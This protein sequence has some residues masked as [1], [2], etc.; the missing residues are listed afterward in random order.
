MR[1]VLGGCWATA[2]IVSL[3]CGAA[4][5]A[6]GDA[7]QPRRGG[8]AEAPVAAPVVESPPQLRPGEIVIKPTGKKRL[9]RAGQR[10]A[11]KVEA[12]LDTREDEN[13]PPPRVVSIGS[14]R[15]DAS[16]RGWGPQIHLAPYSYSYSYPYSSCSSSYGA[17]WLPSYGHGYGRGYG[18]GYGLGFGHRPVGYGGPGLCAPVSRPAVR[19]S[20][21]K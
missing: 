21:G 7:D 18:H 4:A 8:E 13:A 20:R 3:A 9:V 10:P 19:W 14:F 2:T 17:T 5:V 6:R 16:E 12:P 1:H 11:A 15:R